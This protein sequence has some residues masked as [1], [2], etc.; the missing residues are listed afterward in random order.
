MDEIF[1]CK[2]SQTLPHG[3][4][5]MFS[6]K[7]GPYHASYFVMGFCHF[8]YL[9]DTHLYIIDCHSYLVFSDINHNLFIQTHINTGSVFAIV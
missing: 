4:I 2:P 6:S 5:L 7:L 9:I 8:A 1:G 3:Y